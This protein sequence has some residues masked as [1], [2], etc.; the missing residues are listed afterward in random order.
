MDVLV[1]TLTQHR[2]PAWL[3]E[4]RASVPAGIQHRIATASADFQADRW[5]LAHAAEYV[6]WLDDD[7]RLVAGGLE[8]CL[9]VL[10]AD[11]SLGVVF[12][13]E[14]R[15]DEHGARTAE[16]FGART[17]RDVAMHPR[18]LHHLAVVRRG[19]LNP[20]IIGH[21]QRIGCG[22][23]WLMRA[24][25]ALQWGAVHVPVLGYEWRDHSDTLTRRP[26]DSSVYEHAMPLL[27]AVTR[28]WMKYDC[29]IRQH[30]V[31]PA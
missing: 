6:A 8:H 15:I 11:R 16:D 28:S 4:A 18:G 7:D 20:S 25:A 27:R 14:A 23:D 10:D 13:H 2:R 24:S 5:E 1:V 3:A 30:Q 21:A 17:Y 9:E 12:T 29:P 22:I 31:S 19:A 26:D